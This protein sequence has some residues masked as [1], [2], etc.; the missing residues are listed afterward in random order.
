[1]KNVF[2]FF[3]FFLFAGVCNA[4]EYYYSS[5]IAGSG[6]TYKVT[7]SVKN[8]WGNPT[9]NAG[10]IQDQSTNYGNFRILDA[11]ACCSTNS[12]PSDTGKIEVE[13]DG[14]VL[15]LVARNI[16]E[17]GAEFCLTQLAVG[18][19][20]SR[21]YIYHQ[22][23]NWPGLPCAWFCEPGYDG[24]A[25]KDSTSEDSA[26]NTTDYAQW[27]SQRHSAT[28][29]KGNDSITLHNKRIG[30][31][32]FTAV[33]DSLDVHNF[34]P[35][36]I[37]VGAVDFKQHGI[38]AKPIVVAGVGNHPTTT[39]LTSS[40]TTSGKEKILCAQGFTKNDK[41]DMSS[42][43]CGSDAWCNGYSSS[44]FN[45]NIHA[46]QLNGVCNVIVC[47]DGK[48]LNSDFSC[49]ECS[50]GAKARC[51]ASGNDLFGRCIECNIGQVMDQETCQCVSARRLSKEVMQYGNKTSSVVLADQCWT[52]EDSEE[53]KK[54]IL[55]E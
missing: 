7:D 14:A 3:V 5:S 26:C 30:V 50:G 18:S 17:H 16:T 15:A 38:S 44:N 54:C 1:M 27:Y 12:L 21:F 47:K 42:K 31:A 46:K 36:Q 9:V 48:A 29:Y 2:V 8:A 35:H 41:C 4:A 33:L 39:F 24:V 25:C 11:W 55:G 32:E 45:S 10:Y 34:Y 37:V 28:P 6:L 20:S 52:K 23:P 51:D 43:N 19:S 13:D 40:A 53:Y 22:Q 49:S